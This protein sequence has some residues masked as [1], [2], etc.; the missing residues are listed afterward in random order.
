MIT[1]TRAFVLLFVFLQAA[2]LL[3][4]PVTVD[5]DLSDWMSVPAGGANLG[6]IARDAA[7]HG[8][9]IWRDAANDERTD[10]AN[11]HAEVDLTELRVTGD[12]SCLYLAARFSNLYV[13]SGPGVLQLQV[14]IDRVPN[15]GVTTFGNLVETSV[16]P[17]GAWEYLIVT[18]FGS[19]S[20]TPA[21]F[22]TDWADVSV[23]GVAV[24]AISIANKLVEIRV[25]WTEIGGAPTSPLR[26]TAAVF[27]SN[28]DDST[29]DVAGTSDALDALTNYDDPGLSA[30]TWAEVADGTVDYNFEVWFH[31]DPDVE[32]SAPVLI[33]EV[34]SAPTTYDP[35]QE[36]VELRNVSNV[37]LDLGG[38]RLGDEETPDGA[39]GMMAFPTGTVFAPQDVLVVANSATLFSSA[40]P[41]NPDYELNETGP[42]VP[43]LTRPTAWAAGVPT[44]A[45]PG[46]EVLL[47][48]SHWT[49]LDVVTWGSG[50]YP[51]VVDGATTPTGSSLSRRGADDTD[52]CSVDFEV[53]ADPTPGV[54]DP[55]AVPG[56]SMIGLLAQNFPNPFNPS[57]TLRFSL[58][59]GGQVRLV[60]HD[61]R[62]RAVREMATGFY[63]AGDH[64]VVW[65]GRDGA[66]RPLAS[67]DY[68]ARL[69]AGGREQ[70]VGMSLVR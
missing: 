10:F 37:T 53:L 62:G 59:A 52:D 65:D 41:A 22:N 27:C 20:A 5:G 67:G 12:A 24:S 7:L 17:A 3:A 31:L 46:D 19:G 13:A 33:N 1:R 56:P 70:T 11:P 21:V 45:N 66:G 4:H 6:R 38:W 25:P 54:S 60:I 58:P 30:N 14:A 47:L 42:A 23:P 29:W 36:W 44:L 16:S 8:E 57:T 15:E 61:A 40:W 2:P 39:E 32:P 26:F 64:R 18:R 48:D 50:V 51:G 35:Q 34:L 63:P 43:N 68:F 69:L 28:G 49:A 55:T 9:F